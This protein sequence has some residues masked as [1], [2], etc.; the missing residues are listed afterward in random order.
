MQTQEP[1]LVTPEN[2]EPTIQP[3]RDIVRPWWRASLTILPTFLLTRFIFLLLAYFGGV[4]FTVANFSPIPVSY[5][6]LL[7]A[8]NRGDILSYLA[9][10]TD[11]YTKPDQALFFPLYPAL[12]RTLAPLFKHSV[13]TASFFLSNLAFL[14]VLIVLYR[15]VETEFD[16]DTA[17]RATLYLAIFPTA[18]FFFVAYSESLFLLFVLLSFYTMRHG[19]WWLA[20]LF[21]A[22]ATLTQFAGIFL[23][24]VFLCE[25]IRQAGPQIRQAWHPQHAMQR[26]RLASNALAGLLIPLSI[27]IYAYALNLI[28][29]DPFAFMHAQLQHSAGLSAPWAGPLVASKAIVS[30]PLFSFAVAHNVLDLTALLLFLVLLILCF[31]GPERFARSQW[32][33]AVFGLFLLLYALLFPGIPATNGLPYDS[34]P[35]MQRLVL[36]IFPGF[37]LLARFGRRAWFHQSYL[38]LALPLLAFFVLQFITGHWIV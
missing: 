22:L 24:V 4:L 16:R 3:W 26:V 17:K 36:S 35:S 11:G 15:L 32:T 18:F 5:H 1:A 23:F 33:F 27:A 8:W 10:A 12:I 21:G 37:M 28:F 38:L 13:L 29:S 34:L 20:G 7:A 9:I 30:L 6:D 14:G 19:S 25:F 2:A 31:F